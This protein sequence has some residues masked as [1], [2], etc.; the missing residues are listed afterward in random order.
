[1]INILLV[2]DDKEAT[3]ATLD[4]ACYVARLTASRLTAISMQG[5]L[6]GELQA[7]RI[8]NNLANLQLGQI[9]YHFHQRCISRDVT[10]G[11]NIDSIENWE[12]LINASRYA[13][14]IIVDAN[15][16]LNIDSTEGS[17]THYVK[18]LLHEAEC[19]IIIAPSVFEEIDEIVLTYD[20]SKT[21]VYAIKQ[22]AYLFPEFKNK[23]VIA[24]QVNEHS[25]QDI[26]VSNQFK[27]WLDN[28][29]TDIEFVMLEGDSE[30]RL[31]EYLL[32]RH[33]AFIVMGGYSRNRWSRI[34]QPSSSAAIVKLLPAPIFVA[35]S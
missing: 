13:D 25:G 18:K 32:S 19:P 21:S 8:L 16:S 23:K 33:N 24:L 15:L 4:F 9:A 20:N 1:M 35:H 34:L 2:I 14:I 5:L 17:P 12:E 7:D 27:N 22:F 30:N 6:Y 11:E 26:E 28:H 3:T 29:F 10:T 31:M